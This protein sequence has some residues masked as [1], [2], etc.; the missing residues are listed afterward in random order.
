MTPEDLIKV[1]E[2]LYELSLKV[3]QVDANS[4]YEQFL[5]SK[6]FAYDKMDSVT[7]NGLSAIKL[8]GVTTDSPVGV[9]VV[10]T[11]IKV[12]DKMFAFNY[13][14]NPLSDEERKAAEGIINSF[15]AN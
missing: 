7:I 8:T 1:N 2:S 5:S 15:M 9:T 14:G 3:Y 12:A 11:F 4:T 6:N 10:N 13:S